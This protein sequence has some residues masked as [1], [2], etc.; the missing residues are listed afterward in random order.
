MLE[1]CFFALEKNLSTPFR[2]RTKGPSS[3]FSF[4]FISQHSPRGLPVHPRKAAT[5]DLQFPCRKREEKGGNDVIYQSDEIRERERKHSRLRTLLS[6]F[7]TS[8]RKKE[9]EALYLLCVL[10][11]I[12]MQ[13]KGVGVFWFLYGYIWYYCTTTRGTKRIRESRKK[14]KL[15]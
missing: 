15:F 10:V 3:D 11:G 5:N 14:R 1:V 4:P 6:S 13:W 12:Y 9:E 2:K 7:C 8:G